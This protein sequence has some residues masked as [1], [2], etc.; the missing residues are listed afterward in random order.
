MTVMP[1]W[2]MSSHHSGVPKNA[3]VIELFYTRYSRKIPF[4]TQ[5]TQNCEKKKRNKILKRTD[6]KDVHQYD[7]LIKKSKK[8]SA[9]HNT[10]GRL[11]TE[12]KSIGT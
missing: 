7:L 10:T 8:K 11:K 3:K 12:A 9:G 6:S 5:I 2:L 1:A 4:P